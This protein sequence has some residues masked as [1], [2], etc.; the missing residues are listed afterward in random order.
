M[1]C[2][3]CGSQLAEGSRFCS[4]CGH[5]FDRSPAPPA[6]PVR[7]SA[8]ETAPASASLWMAITSMVLA[9]VT[10]LALLSSGSDLDTLDQLGQVESLFGGHTLKR[11]AAEEAL[12]AAI[13]G[14]VFVLPAGI[15]GIVSLTQRR[16]GRG[17]AITGVV[18][19]AINLLMVLGIF[20]MAI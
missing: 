10:L 19:S 14:L 11:K 13:G 17:M 8:P 3:N 2:P 1:Y 18:L 9:I 6:V 16:G 12:N 4:Q 5:G 20:G 15:L 7:P